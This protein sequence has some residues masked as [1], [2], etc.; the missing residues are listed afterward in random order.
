MNKLKEFFTRF[1]NISLKILML[2]L[3]FATL[4]LAKYLIDNNNKNISTLITTLCLIIFTTAVIIIVSFTS[5]KKGSTVEA[6]S[7]L[8]LSD[9][10]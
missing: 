8:L 5:L 6:L 10:Y 1:I 4:T 7:S 9:S 2:I 3:I